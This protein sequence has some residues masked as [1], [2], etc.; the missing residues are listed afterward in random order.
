MIESVP[1]V[2]PLLAGGTVP[3]RRSEAVRAGIDMGVGEQVRVVLTASQSGTRSVGHADR[4]TIGRAL[5]CIIRFE[6]ESATSVSR[7][8]S[9]ISAANGTV[10][11][12]DAGS[13]H[14]TFLNGKKIDGAA[15]LRSG[16]AIMLGP[17]GPTFV[18]EEASVDGA[19]SSPDAGAP[20]TAPP[21]AYAR[22]APAA[23]PHKPPPPRGADEVFKAELPTPAFAR[24]AIKLPPEKS[25]LVQPSRPVAAAPAEAKASPVTVASNRGRLGIIAAVAAAVALAAFI[26]IQRVSR[27]QAALAEANVKIAQQAAALE[28]ARAVAANDAIAA[29]LSLDSAIK[30]AAAPSALDSIRKAIADAER[31]ASPQK[32]R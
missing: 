23:V 28:S 7:V 30:A 12:R 11:V 9:E 19:A 1:V 24:A 16:D 4:V 25:E 3:M 8:H 14:G 17:G 13:R 21:H 20:A 2:P 22:P 26:A 29:R 10:V 27:T 18:V 15:P 32:D 31:R 6:G 5:E